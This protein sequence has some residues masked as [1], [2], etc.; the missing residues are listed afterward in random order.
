MKP[1]D[2]IPPAV[3]AAALVSIAALSITARGLPLLWVFAAAI[4]LSPFVSYRLV[5]G[6][7]LRWLVRIMLIATVIVLTRDDPNN[8][9]EGF[10]PTHTR[11][12]FGEICAAEMAYQFWRRRS[13]DPRLSTLCILMT[14]GLVFLTASNTFEE[15]FIRFI[16]PVYLLCIAFAA[17]GY[18]AR[19]TKPVPRRVAVTSTVLTGSAVVAALAFGILGYRTTIVYRSVLTEMGNKVILKGDWAN[20][21]SGMSGQPSL[22]PVF[23]LRGSAVR[24][25]RISSFSG[26]EHLVGVDYSTY[27]SGQWGP[28]V[29]ERHWESIS[30]GVLTAPASS[31]QRGTT[32]QMFMTRLVN[33]NPLIFLPMAT[34]S[35]DFGD[36]R[37]MSRAADS[38]VPIRVRARAPY[39]YTVEVSQNELYQGIPAEP[40]T[41]AAREDDL[42][43]PSDDPDEPNP[44]MDKVGQLAQSIA[45]HI[46]DPKKRVEAIAQYLLTH[47][48]YSL[49]YHPSGSIHEPLA[50][51]I[52][53]QPPKAAHCEFFASAAAIMLRYVSVPTRYVTG[54]FVH[55]A[56]RNGDMIVR[57]RDAHAWCEAWIKGTGWVTVEATPVS[58]RP[59][60]PD[61]ETKVEPW[62]RVWE[63]FQDKGQAFS[64]FLA[65][66]TLAQIGGVTMAV[67]VGVAGLIALRSYARR[68]G[69]RNLAGT[70][71]RHY[72]GPSSPEME[73]L[74]RRFEAFWAR[75]SG[76]PLPMNR[77]YAEFFRAYPAGE[78]QAN[79]DQAARLRAF[80]ELYEAARFGGRNDAAVRRQLENLLM[81]ME[82]SLH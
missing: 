7:M 57:Q 61:P 12:L 56:D 39:D 23:G 72:S 36:E 41:P 24:I 64:E 47:H 11:D 6:T 9:F 55:E 31:K 27:Q 37:N 28:A 82:A 5:N 65:N 80:A 62:R 4:L 49:T 14:S 38:G 69:L 20:E 53:S 79:R 54:Y 77:S 66:I 42:T 10:G 3:F 43:T 74:A 76:A 15:T 46:L 22:G 13:Y 26:D 45:G 35:I 73:G 16:T 44:D 21:G 18:R 59:D 63:W 34:S 51:F 33:D 19:S 67:T 71:A 58:G 32:S 70:G 78:D 25:L 60:S 30:S 75:R 81:E 2:R 48:A 40:L 1:E 29:P 17:T 52:L 68:R 8:A 50:D